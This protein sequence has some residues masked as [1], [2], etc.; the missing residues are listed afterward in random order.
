MVLFYFIFFFSASKDGEKGYQY[1]HKVGSKSIAPPSAYCFHHIAKIFHG[2]VNVG[3]GEVSESFIPL[4]SSRLLGPGPPPHSKPALIQAFA[5]LWVNSHTGHWEGQYWAILGW[6][7]WVRKRIEER[8]L[9]S[10]G[11]SQKQSKQDVWEKK[12]QEHSHTFLLERRMENVEGPRRQRCECRGSRGDER[13]QL[14]QEKE[15]FFLLISKS[16]FEYFLFLRF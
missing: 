13:F 4:Y 8:K 2:K 5:K 10:T 9:C 7:R 6:V 14:L 1:A 15:Y 12:G 16:V 11:C 3:S